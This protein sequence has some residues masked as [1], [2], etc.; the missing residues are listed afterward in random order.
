MLRRA[1]LGLL[2]VLGACG[3]A[4]V[5]WRTQTGGVI[6]LQGDRGKSMEVANGEMAG[7]CGA[8]NWT[9]V[10][11]GYEPVGTDR[12]YGQTSTPYAQGGTR[13]TGYESQRASMIWRIHYQCNNAYVPNAMPAAGP[14][15]PMPQEPPPPPPPPP[16]NY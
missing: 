16:S 2:V 7:H 6:E 8:N 13:T 12:Y 9:I 1:S 5:V 3:T 15:E 11:E 4:R 14:G 10:A